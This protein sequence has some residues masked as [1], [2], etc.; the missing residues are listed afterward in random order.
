MNILLG[1]LYLSILQYRPNIEDKIIEAICGLSDREVL[2]VFN[3]WR[4]MSDYKIKIEMG[5]SN[6]SNR[7]LLWWYLTIKYNR[8]LIGVVRSDGILV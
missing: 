4:G 8:D 7:H 5:I 1:T 6:I 2:L 3:K